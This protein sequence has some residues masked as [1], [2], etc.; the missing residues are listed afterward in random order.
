MKKLLLIASVMLAMSAQSPL[1]SPI[2][3]S[4]GAGGSVTSIATTSPITGG[5]I[6][7]TGTIACATCVVASSPGAGL[8]R[9]AGSTQ[10]VTSAELSGDVSTS[11]S[12]AVTV[13]KVNGIAYS[14]TAA[15]HTVQV[16]TTANTTATAKVMP[17]CTD[18]GGNH[19]NFTQSTDA[20]SC[21]TSGGGGTLT[22]PIFV[23]SP[24][25]HQTNYSHTINVLTCRDFTLYV[26]TTVSN[27]YGRVQIADS[28]KYWGAALYDSSGNRL[29]ASTSAGSLL[30][31]TGASIVALSGAT[32]LSAGRNTLCTE[33]NSGTA[34]FLGEG[35]AFGYAQDP[36]NPILYTAANAASTSGSTITWP[37]TLGAKTPVGGG[38]TGVWSLLN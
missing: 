25:F 35:D 10:T 4:G 12:N 32:T 3:G 26:S 21:G 36:S 6:T 29:T 13:T 5:T 15:A 31:S 30:T 14:A 17:D 1:P 2:N 20:F 34:A 8:S 23:S 19:L 9:F 22:A 37:A 18:T 33:N 11:G 16:T 7:T 24:I 28:G 27:L 38:T